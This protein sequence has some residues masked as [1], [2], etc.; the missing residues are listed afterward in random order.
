MNRVKIHKRIRAKIKGTSEAPRLSVFKS[1]KPTYA[2]L[3]DDEKGITL[4]AAHDGEVKAKKGTTKSESARLVGEEVAKK[5]VAKGIKK[6][7]FDRG[8]FQYHG[9]VLEIA[10]GARSGGLK[11]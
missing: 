9:R 6:A 1:S 8:G 2:Q 4:A 11:F 5:A 10:E 3:I 7:V